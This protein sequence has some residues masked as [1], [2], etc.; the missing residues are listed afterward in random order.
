MVTNCSAIGGHFH[1]WIERKN[2][3]LQKDW[4]EGVWWWSIA[5][6]YIIFPKLLNFLPI[7]IF[8]KYQPAWGCRVLRGDRDILFDGGVTHPQKIEPWYEP[9]C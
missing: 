6:F 4:L 5:Y 7:H 2:F 9:K 3:W 8:Q 1:Y